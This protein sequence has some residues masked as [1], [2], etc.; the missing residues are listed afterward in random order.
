MAGKIP[1]VVLPPSL[2][3]G[4]VAPTNQPQT[5]LAVGEKLETFLPE[6]NDFT[7]KF[8]LQNFNSF[9]SSYVL[10]KNNSQQAHMMHI[11]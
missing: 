11:A 7:A 8:L 1:R 9:S 10:Q 4:R 6:I 5:M 3:R 2:G